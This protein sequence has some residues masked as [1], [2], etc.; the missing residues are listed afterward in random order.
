MAIPGSESPSGSL[1]LRKPVK[2]KTKDKTS[3]FGYRSSDQRPVVGEVDYVR[4]PS[5]RDGRRHDNP[6]GM[7][8]VACPGASC[9]MRFRYRLAD[10][11]TRKGSANAAD[12]GAIPSSIAR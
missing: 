11:G 10:S 2:R 7:S 6:S 12:G 4:E 3:P 1:P 9:G 5:W 8:P